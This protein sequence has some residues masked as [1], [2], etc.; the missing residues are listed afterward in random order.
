MQFSIFPDAFH[1]ERTYTLTAQELVEAIASGR[2]QAPVEQ[3]RKAKTKDHRNELKKA[4]PVATLSGTFTARKTSE[5]I[6][7]SGLLQLDIDD[8]KNPAH[9]RDLLITDPHIIA[10]FISPSGTGVKGIMLIPADAEKHKDAFRTAQQ[11]MGDHYE[12]TLD[13][14]CSD[15][16]RGMFVSYD[17]QARIDLDKRP[18]EVKA[19]PKPKLIKRHFDA[20]SQEAET[21]ASALKV[22]PAD[23][24]ERW[25]RMGMALKAS[26]LPDGQAYALWDAWSASASNYAGSKDTEAR[27]KGFTDGGGITAA[28]LVQEAK[29]WGWQPPAAPRRARPALTVIEGNTARKVEPEPEALADDLPN[30][31]LN[32]KGKI[33]PILA[34]AEAL[35]RHYIGQSIASDEWSHATMIT[36]ALPWGSQPGPWRAIDDTRCTVWLQ[37]LGCSMSSIRM[38]AAAVESVADERKVHPLRDFLNGLVWDGVERL[39]HWLADYVGAPQ[40]IYMGTIGRKWLCAAVARIFEPGIKF[41]SMLVLEGP[42]GIG[43]STILATLG[44]TWFSDDFPDMHGKAAAER[45]VGSWIIELSELDALGRSEVSAVKAFISRRTDRYRPAY[46]TRVEEYPRTCIFAGSVNPNGS[47]YL[48]DSTGNRR[49]WPV[50]CTDVNVDGLREVRDQ[51]LAEALHVWRAGEKL[52]LDDEQAMQEAKAMQEERQQADP[53]ESTIVNFLE[54]TTQENVGFDDLYNALRL[55]AQHQNQG[56]ANRISS[57]LQRE[58]WSRFRSSL[59]GRPW[60]YRKNSAK[61]A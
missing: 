34:N 36:Q 27:W 33:Q 31:L 22:I 46:G 49:F 9:V 61:N 38:V 52:Y 58:G 37:H 5:L 39:D 15:V 19:A 57:I 41:D 7:H 54:S 35:I 23:D 25:V 3:I 26:K 11:Y 16:A 21:L 47:G 18:L 14:A 13:R 59:P 17:P 42:Q 2:W 45:T 10:S 24:Y 53:W 50:P 40:T 56:T 6:Q 60:R 48:R 28:S 4:L 44:G 30:L 29:D 51:L 8:V 1:T 43:K 20:D 55:D 12:L 32:E